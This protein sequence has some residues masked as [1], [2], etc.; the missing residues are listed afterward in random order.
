[1]TKERRQTKL[2]FFQS[3]TLESQKHLFTSGRDVG[4]P[5]IVPVPFFLIDHPKGR[6]LFDTG[7][8]AEVAYDADRH[9]G[10]ATKAYLPHMKP[11]EFVVP[12][13][14]SIGI[15]PEQIDIVVLSHL[16]LDHAGGV[17]CF[18]N[19]RYIVQK[20]ELE[21]AY[22]PDDNQKAAYIRQDFDKPVDWWPLN[23]WDDDGF[24]LFG[25]GQ[26]QIW[27]TPGH[28]PGHQSL[29]IRLDDMGEILLAADSCYTDEILDQ[30]IVPGLVWNREVA[31]QT[32]RRLKMARDQQNIKIIAGHDPKAWSNFNLSPCTYT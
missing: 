23:G 25:D 3:G 4:V 11:Q 24:D 16:H 1:M 27:F 12:Q 20:T 29:F 13:L 14:M 21:W 22:H 5:F 19:A 28:T 31:L 8:A 17:G 32:I 6:V 26:I 15:A 18:P 2:M 10:I 30:E 9:W 7:N